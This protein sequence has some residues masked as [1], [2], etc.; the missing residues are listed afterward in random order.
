NCVQASLAK[1]RL[2][3]K[4]GDHTRAV[5]D[6]EKL[7]K[8]RPKDAA[9]CYEA[10]M[11]YGQHKE[12]QPSLRCLRQAAELEPENRKYSNSLR[13]ALARCGQ[14]DESYE[15]FRKTVGD[16]KAHYHL[17]QMLHYLQQD[18][19]SKQQLQLALQADPNLAPAQQ[20]WVQLQN[21]TA[22]AVQQAQFET[23]NQ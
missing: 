17:A 20:M 8:A 1:A 18:E 3:A 9:I 23:A 15:I 7:L 2:H 13:F 19:L 4:M 14:K 12:W 10:G 5:T 6:Y 16:A 22:P 11:Y 21:G